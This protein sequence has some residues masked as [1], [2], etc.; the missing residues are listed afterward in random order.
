MSGNRIEILASKLARNRYKVQ[1]DTQGVFT[2]PAEVV[3]QYAIYEGK[4]FALPEWVAILRQAEDVDCYAKLLGLLGQRFHSRMELMRKLRNR[5]FSKYAVER[6]LAKAEG[7]GLVDDRRFAALMAEEK[8]RVARASKR[9]IV[10]DLRKRGVT[11]AIVDEVLGEM[12]EEFSNENVMEQALAVARQRQ[13]QWAREEDPRKKK[14][15]I[16]RFL[17]S[18]GFSAGI[19]YDV[20]RKVMAGEMDD[21]E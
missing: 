13:Y 19:C 10:A 18:R 1:T 16:L 7:L 2:L 6:A 20:V 3:F 14:E 9:A 21:D 15:K 4:A 12:T 5:K 17:A 8:L 11:G